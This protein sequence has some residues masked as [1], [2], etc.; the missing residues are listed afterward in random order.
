MGEK[1]EAE[2]M[3]ALTVDKLR[4]HL[5]V[6]VKA[7]EPLVK[8]LE[9]A[10]QNAIIDLTVARQLRCNPV[11]ETGRCLPMPI[12]LDELR[13]GDV[14]GV[15]RGVFELARNVHTGLAEVDQSYSFGIRDP[16]GDK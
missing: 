8:A 3:E 11:A 1:E 2:K 5:D 14:A 12:S 16:K 13:T 9:S 6:A 7:L 10:K 4:E 15:L